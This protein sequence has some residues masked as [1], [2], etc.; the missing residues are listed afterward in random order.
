MGLFSK[1]CA[2]GASRIEDR[3]HPERAGKANRTQ[4][5]SMKMR[6]MAKRLAAGVHLT[7]DL[8]NMIYGRMQFLVR[9]P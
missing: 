8:R 1:F 6:K 7:G 4:Q 2:R 3:S 5:W 9:G